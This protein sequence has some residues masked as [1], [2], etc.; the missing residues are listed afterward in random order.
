MQCRCSNALH[1]GC[2]WVP[3][4]TSVSIRCCSPCV[5]RQYQL[6]RFFLFNEL[7]RE[8]NE[9]FYLPEICGAIWCHRC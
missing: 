4:Q 2:A 7:S 8:L 1:A 5:G 9:Y 6:N 3:S